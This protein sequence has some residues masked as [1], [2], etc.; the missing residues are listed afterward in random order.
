[1]K[2]ELWLCCPPKSSLSRSE[3][4]KVNLWLTKTQQTCCSVQCSN[5]MCIIKLGFRQ[6]SAISDVNM[7]YSIFILGK[8]S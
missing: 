2:S 7:M 6:Y 3:P 5:K 1:M 4:L 8:V